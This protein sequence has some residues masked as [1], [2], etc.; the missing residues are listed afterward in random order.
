MCKYLNSRWCCLVVLSWTK[1][2]G[3][4][5]KVVML[6]W[7]P[8][9]LVAFARQPRH[10]EER[11]RPLLQAPHSQSTASNIF[12]SAHAFT[13]SPRSRFRAGSWVPSPPPPPLKG[14]HPLV[15]SPPPTP[16]ICATPSPGWRT[17][18]SKF[19]SHFPYADDKIRRVIEACG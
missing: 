3:L 7:G 18:G 5:G 9:F 1:L 14:S 19:P 6:G 10:R 12:L 15:A 8:L 11:P 17:L 4:H 2:L 13:L 16:T